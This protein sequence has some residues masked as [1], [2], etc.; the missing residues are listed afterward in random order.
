MVLIRVATLA[1]WWAGTLAVLKVLL[2]VEKK[3]SD[4]AEKMAELRVVMSAV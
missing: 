4:W 1:A 2:T 3:V